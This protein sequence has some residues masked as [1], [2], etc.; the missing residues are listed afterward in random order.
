MCVF[1]AIQLRTYGFFC[2]IQWG[3]W[4]SVTHHY[5]LLCLFSYG[6]L[7]KEK[8][9]PSC[10]PLLPMRLGYYSCWRWTEWQSN[11]PQ[12]LLVK[13]S[14]VQSRGWQFSPNLIKLH[15]V[16][17]QLPVSHCRIVW[18]LFCFKNMTQN[19]LIMPQTSWKPSRLHLSLDCWPQCKSKNP[20][21]NF[22]S[23]PAE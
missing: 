7:I 15:L 2:V 4:R 8:T 5:S 22:P 13:T 11:V 16:L 12:T 9:D 18:M 14:L 19:R 6:E 20:A 21:S 17:N 10:L 1:K 23:N 3:W